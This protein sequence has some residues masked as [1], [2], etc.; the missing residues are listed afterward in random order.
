MGEKRKPSFIFNLKSINPISE[1]VLKNKVEC[2]PSE[3]FGYAVPR[4]TSQNTYRLRVNGKWYPK[5]GTTQ[6]Y[7]KLQIISM[8]QKSITTL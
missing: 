6:F 3:L 4:R 1:R 2:F 8:L 5:S 7:T